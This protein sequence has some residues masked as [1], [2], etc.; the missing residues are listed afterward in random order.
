MR[1]AVILL[2]SAD[3]H[4]L[5]PVLGVTVGYRQAAVDSLNRVVVNAGAFVQRVGKLVLAAANQRL[6]A[7]HIVARTFAFREI[8]ACHRHG[9]VRQGVAII[10]L[11][12]RRAGQRYV[13]LGD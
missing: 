8:V 11:A 7:G 10:L 12:V 2:T 4:N 3:R 6:A 1:I 5:D 13:P 9:I